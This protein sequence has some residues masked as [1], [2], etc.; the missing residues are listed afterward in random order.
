M[1]RY[2]VG[3]TLHVSPSDSAAPVV[4]SITTAAF[5]TYVM[6]ARL[7]RASPGSTQRIVLTRP[8]PWWPRFFMWKPSDQHART[9]PAVVLFLRV[10]RVLWCL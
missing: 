4:E 7:S 8:G 3:A 5:V 2:A 10:L 6:S 1:S 9:T